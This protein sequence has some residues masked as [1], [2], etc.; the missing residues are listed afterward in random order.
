MTQVSF[1]KKLKSLK[2]TTADGILKYRW[3]IR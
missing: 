1:C 2:D 3:Y